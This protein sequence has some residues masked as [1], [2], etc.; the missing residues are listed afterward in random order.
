[1]NVRLDG[2]AAGSIDA[3]GVEAQP[4]SIF[5]RPCRVM[6]SP[7]GAALAAGLPGQ[8]GAHEAALEVVARRL[9]AERR[10]RPARRCAGSNDAADAAAPRA[11]T[12]SDAITFCSS[13]TLPGQS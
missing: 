4:L 1:M 12:A 11:C 3:A 10:Q 9:E 6:P 13:R 8:R 2:A 7:R 5:A